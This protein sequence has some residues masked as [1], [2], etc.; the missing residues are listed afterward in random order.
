MGAGWLL[1]LFIPIEPLS[2]RRFRRRRRHEFSFS[3]FVLSNPPSFLSSLLPP[4]FGVIP[5]LSCPEDRTGKQEV[6]RRG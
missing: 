2:G 6:G 1:F 5:A 3:T 4:S